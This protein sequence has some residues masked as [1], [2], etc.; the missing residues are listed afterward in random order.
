MRFLH[1]DR[2][3]VQKGEPFVEVEAMK[4]I[5]ALKAGEAGVITQH[6]SPGSIVGAG[7]LIASL[8]L[9]DL[10]KIKQIHPF[11]GT[12]PLQIP[13][14]YPSI[15]HLFSYRSAVFLA[16]LDCSYSRGCSGYADAGRGRILCSRC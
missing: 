15:A 7:D 14:L 1:P 13:S 5:M 8:E 11:T 9:Q 12:I 10:S 2:S 16:P 3:F 6:L 4:M